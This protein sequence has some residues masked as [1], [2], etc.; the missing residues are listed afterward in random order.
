MRNNKDTIDKGLKKG[1][2]MIEEAIISSLR[3]SCQA[4]LREVQFHRS[5]AGFT[6]QTQTSYMAGLYVNGKLRV[7]F[8]ERNWLERP[9]RSKVPLNKFVW[10][11]NPYEGQ[12]RGVRGA[13]DIDDPSGVRLSTQILQEYNP[14]K[15]GWAIMVT[16]GTEYSE[17][18][19]VVNHLDVLTGTYEEAANIINKNW[20]KIPD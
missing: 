7:L 6:G 8:N 15:D 17:I 13:V 2:Q 3:E 11:D 10:L 4:L 20:K 19:E 9:R 12:S 16:T 5:Y 1:L 18:N 14:P